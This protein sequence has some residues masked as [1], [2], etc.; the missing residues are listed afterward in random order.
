MDLAKVCAILT[1]DVCQRLGLV[2]ER[3]FM[4]GPELLIGIVSID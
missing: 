3:R 4:K 1:L 2:D